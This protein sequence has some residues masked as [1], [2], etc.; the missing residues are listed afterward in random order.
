MLGH[1]PAPSHTPPPA[2]KQSK[3]ADLGAHGRGEGSE[4]GLET[5]PPRNPIFSPPCPQH[6]I[7]EGMR[8][9]DE[10]LRKTGKKILH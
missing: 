1:P 7:A 9:W 8:E 6:H 2:P 3:G 4:N 10:E 5:P